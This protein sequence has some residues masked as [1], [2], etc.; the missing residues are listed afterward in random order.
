[1]LYTAQDSTDPS[2]QRHLL[3]LWVAAPNGLPL[4]EDSH[5]KETWGTTQI[6]DRGGYWLGHNYSKHVPLD[7]EYGD[8][9]ETR[10]KPKAAA[11]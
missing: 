8:L 9:E 5:Y 2:K 10:P 4:P 11:V 1:M 6:G 7:P 3:R